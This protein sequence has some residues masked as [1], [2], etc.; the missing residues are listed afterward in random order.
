M[1]TF[2]LIKKTAPRSE[3]TAV[4]IIKLSHYIVEKTPFVFV[5]MFISM[6]RALS[7]KVIQG[8]LRPP[9]AKDPWEL[10]IAE[11]LHGYT[12]SEDNVVLWLITIW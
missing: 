6:H 10:S 7:K 5:F 1:L 2:W 12:L 3:D 4:F 11:R 9:L 8:W